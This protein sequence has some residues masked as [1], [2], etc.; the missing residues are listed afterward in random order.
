MQENAYEISKPVEIFFEKFRFIKLLFEDRFGV[1]RGVSIYN[2]IILDNQLGKS[3]LN[4]RN[5]YREKINNSILFDSLQYQKIPFE[6]FKELNY[7]NMEYRRC[8]TIELMSFYSLVLPQL[9]AKLV[10]CEDGQYD[11]WTYNDINLYTR[12]MI[13]YFSNNAAEV[14]NDIFY[15]TLSK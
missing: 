2:F 10:L 13:N 8:T 14:Y 6:I 15:T 5:Y 9:A 11:I 7:F 3:K 12:R 4:N 1:E